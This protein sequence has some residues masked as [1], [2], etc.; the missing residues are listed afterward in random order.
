MELDVAI[1][2]L[3]TIHQHRIKLFPVNLWDFWFISHY[4]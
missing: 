1:H 4:R 2:Q 3:S